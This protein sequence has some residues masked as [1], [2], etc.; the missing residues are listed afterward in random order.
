[1]TAQRLLGKTAFITGAGR[2]IGRAVALKLASEG[3]RIVLND[4]DDEPAHYVV[5][6]IA[7]MGGNAK[8]VVGSVTENGFA[9]KFINEGLEAFGEIDII[10]NNA[11]YAWDAMIGRMTDDQFDA[12]LNVHAKAPFRILRAAAPHIRER[13]EA[14]AARGEE[15]FRKV[16]NVSSIAGLGGNIG[17]ANY[18]AGKAAV[19]G[20]T[21]TLAKEWGR[22]KVNVNCAA[23][24]YIE[25]RLTEARDTK[26]TVI[27][28]GNAVGVGIPQAT[29]DAFGAQVPLGRGGTTEEA[30]DGVYLL[31]APESNYV[32]GQVLVIGG[33]LIF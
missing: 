10:V 32:S 27:V 28:D 33:G 16:V 24:G 15:V 25:T 21:K 26:E 31:C 11:G 20:L 6:T 12:M 1:M 7:N 8:P 9:E 4:L 3:A 22:Y 19:V 30:A 18:A 14:E 13:A 5:Q 17:Q 2:G 29:A 23:F